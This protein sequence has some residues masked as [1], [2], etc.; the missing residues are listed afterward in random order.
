MK[1]ILRLILILYCNTMYAQIR[2]GAKAGINFN[3]IRTVDMPA[4]FDRF[5]NAF[6][7]H[8]GGFLSGKISDKVMLTPEVQFTQRGASDGDV[9]LNLSYIEVPIML[10]Y[11]PLNIF[12][13][14]AGP[15]VAFKVGGKGKV[16]GRSFRLN[17]AYEKMMDFG[18]NVGVRFNLTE[19]VS[20]YGRYY[21]GL[22][23]IDETVCLTIDANTYHVKEY[24]RSM[25]LGVMYFIR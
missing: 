11:L 23:V 2:W 1:N 22:A 18:A 21:H 10:A 7:F 24:N 3:S 14:E 20:I 17:D 5:D 13:I 25:Q 16:D 12:A 15:S 9:R 6:G 4:E 19:D 8:V